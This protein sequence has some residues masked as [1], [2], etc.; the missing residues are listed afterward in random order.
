[1]QRSPQSVYDYL[2]N[3]ILFIIK[4]PK[5][6]FSVISRCRAIYQYQ[7]IQGLRQ[8]IERDSKQTRSNSVVPTNK[9]SYSQWLKNEPKPPTISLDNRCKYHISII[10]MGQEN[11]VEESNHT[12]K[13]IQQQTVSNWEILL[14]QQQQGHT[15]ISK[16][17]PQQNTVSETVNT[18]VCANILHTALVRINGSYFTILEP[19]DFLIPEALSA[20]SLATQLNRPTIVYCDSDK[21]N[22]KQE[23]SS[24]NFK[25]GWN[26]LLLQGYNYLDRPVFFRRDKICSST[27]FQNDIGLHS[28][29][30]S[31]QISQ[32]LTS[33]DVCHIP[34]ILCHCHDRPTKSSPKTN[35]Q[36]PQI[37]LRKHE[38]IHQSATIHPTVS[39]IIPTRNGLDI[40]ERT[41]TSLTKTNYPN[42]ELLV[43]D[44][45]SDDKATLS[46]L[47]TLK[48]SHTAK[49]LSY[50]QP[51]NYS[52]INNYAVK[53]ANGEIIC[54]LNNDTEVINPSWLSRLVRHAI[55]PVSGAVGP[56]LLYPDDTIQQAG[57]MLGHSAYGPGGLACHAFC[58]HHK[59]YAGQ[60]GR[61]LYA[62]YISAVTGACL[63]VRKSV[64][65]EVKGFDPQLAVTMNDVDLC[66]KIR[67]KGYH[68]ILEPA[69]KLYHHESLSRGTDDNDI[70]QVRSSREILYMRQKWGKI[71]TEDPYFPT[72]ELGT[73]EWV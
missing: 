18:T 47:S 60:N 39:I 40:L 31:Q 72:G 53:Q 3:R 44:N 35:L 5:Q 24:P 6:L 56:L 52:A 34:Y 27:H 69:A 55:A 25:S 67:E 71:L 12:I 23:R 8:A 61:L 7:G 54:F 38:L 30:I 45:S 42:T 57:I 9:R 37:N 65:E 19:G 63:V 62:Q 50:N 64:F 20:L 21:I 15:H 51:F 68:N 70:K 73:I 17:T 32:H 59:D 66:L 11:L 14:I 10:I 43:I 16:I 26:P 36:G 49:V 29:S 22:Q 1:M 28:W 33:K 4:H 13:S 48:R 2:I 58:G 41:I 46:F